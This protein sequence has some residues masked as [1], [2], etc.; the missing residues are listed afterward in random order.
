M[1]PTPKMATHHPGKSKEPSSVEARGGEAPERQDCPADTDTPHN[2]GKFSH[3]DAG[4]HPN[5]AELSVSEPAV[6]EASSEPLLTHAKLKGQK[7]VIVGSPSQ[8]ADGVVCNVSSASRM[9]GIEG[10]LSACQEPGYNNPTN[11]KST[12][13]AEAAEME[14]AMGPF[15]YEEVQELVGRRRI[16]RERGGDR[17]HQQDAVSFE[18]GS[19]V[20]DLRRARM[21][22]EEHQWSSSCLTCRD[23]GPEMSVHP[24]GHWIL[25]CRC[26]HDLFFLGLPS[27][28]VCG[29]PIDEISFTK[30]MMDDIIRRSNRRVE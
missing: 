29:R 16:G 1:E 27:C 7:V 14:R 28:P 23:R 20:V 13:R 30:A 5:S 3:Q 18:G 11:K 6:G 21:Q 9:P 19:P 17:A 26:F 2:F 8:E 4:L 25:C 24:C 22:R 15:F 12:R 10:K